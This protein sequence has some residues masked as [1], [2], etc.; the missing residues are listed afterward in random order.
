MEK[1]HS[2][3]YALYDCKWLI[4]FLTAFSILAGGTVYI[5]LRPSE[6]LFFNLFGIIGLEDWIAL[7]R[8]NTILYGRYFPEWFIFSL[9]NG[10]WVFAYSIVIF[11]IWK[12]SK[13]VLKYFWFASIPVIVFGF[14]FF[15]LTGLL[16]G[17]FS[18]PDL[19]FDFAG[20]LTGYFTAIKLI[21]I[22]SHD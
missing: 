17:T 2:T 14:E 19:V 6:P 15:Q 13:S 11:S 18:I 7:L 5:L 4:I 16:R 22:K 21:K 1:K 10:L 3:R 20:L 12:S 8:E 9:P